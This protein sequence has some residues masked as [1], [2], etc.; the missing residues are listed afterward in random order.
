MTL[1]GTWSG[2]AWRRDQGMADVTSRVPANGILIRMLYT[3][4]CGTDRQILAGQRPDQASVLGHEGV[5][6]CVAAG[7]AALEG[8]IGRAVVFNPVCPDR[9]ATVLGHSFDGLFRTYVPVTDDQLRWGM[10]VPLPG[11]LETTPDLVLAEPL[12]T[13]VYGLQ[14]MRAARPEPRR[15]AIIGGGAQ[16]RLRHALLRDAGVRTV[17]L[18]RHPAARW[19]RARAAGDVDAR[20]WPPEGGRPAGSQFGWVCVCVSAAVALPSVRLALEL[21]A[22]A[23]AVEL[24]GGFGGQRG[25]VSRVLGFDA[26]APRWRDTCGRASAPD[27]GCTYA[28]KEVAVIGHRGTSADHLDQ[29]V[30]WIRSGA[31]ARHEPAAVTVIPAGSQA[32][33]VVSATAPWDLPALRLVLDW[34]ADGTEGLS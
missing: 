18:T 31:L 17:V 25:D 21:V 23:G 19:I 13:A 9:P 14:L 12:G 20:A 34:A 26:E 15:V 5:G 7:H 27:G 28:A 1:A 16:A 8:W 11:A 6:V 2:T 24:V 3:G 30:R 4:V 33:A 32:P 10:V 29:A 22:P